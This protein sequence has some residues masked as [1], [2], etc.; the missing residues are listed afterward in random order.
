MTIGTYTEATSV[1]GKDASCTLTSQEYI[2]IMAIILNKP[3]DIVAIL[4]EEAELVLCN[5]CS[6]DYRDQNKHYDDVLTRIPIL[7]K[8]THISDKC[9][10]CYG[11]LLDTEF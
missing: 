7:A 9:D 8:H 5:A 3:D 10:V 11:R 4:H 2:S 6:K 1:F